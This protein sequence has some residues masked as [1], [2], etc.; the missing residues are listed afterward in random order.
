MVI[1]DSRTMVHEL[2]GNNEERSAIRDPVGPH[3]AKWISRK[4]PH[5]LT[6]LDR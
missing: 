2:V 5:P 6:K 4:L 3:N 1:N